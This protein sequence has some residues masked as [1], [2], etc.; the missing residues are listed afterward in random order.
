MPM[1]KMSLSLFSGL[2]RIMMAPTCATASVR[3]VGGRVGVC[4]GSTASTSSLRETFLS[5]TIRLSGSNS[6][7][8]STSRNGYRCGRLR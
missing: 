6:V 3:I 4:P 7:I 8:R 1:K 2:A 5:P